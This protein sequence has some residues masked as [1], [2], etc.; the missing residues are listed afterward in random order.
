MIELALILWNV[1]ILIGITQENLTLGLYF[2][3]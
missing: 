3:K 1:V 2:I